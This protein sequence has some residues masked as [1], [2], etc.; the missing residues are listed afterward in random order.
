[1]VHDLHG[2]TR[3][4]EQFRYAYDAGG[5]LTWRTNNNL[6]MRF[7]A[8]GMNQ[9][10]NVSRTGTITVSGAMDQPSGGAT[11]SAVGTGLPTTAADVYS[12]GTW[13]SQNAATLADGQNT[14]MA[15]I[16]ANGQT[17]YQTVS[18]YMPANISLAYDA[19]GILTKEVQYKNGTYRGK[20]GKIKWNLRLAVWTETGAQSQAGTLLHE[21]RH[22]DHLKES[23]E[24]VA[25]FQNKCAQELPGEGVR[26]GYYAWETTFEVDGPTQHGPKPPRPPLSAETK[27]RLPQ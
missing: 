27:S 4:H 15:T 2:E 12:D 26:K 11:I 9:L 23:D 24:Q 3:R 6:K 19:N 1:L 17:T 21:L 25:A 18:A 8:N 14:Y 13:A 10:T 7:K 16:T 5:S 22:A 20:D